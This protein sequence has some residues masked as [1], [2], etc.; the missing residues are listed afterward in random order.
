[1]CSVVSFPEHLAKRRGTTVNI[2]LLVDASRIDGLERAISGFG[3][4]K[5]DWFGVGKKPCFRVV[6]FKLP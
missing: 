4:G 2:H 5:G 1:M 6:G 3:G